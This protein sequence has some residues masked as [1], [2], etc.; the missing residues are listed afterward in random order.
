MQIH[1]TFHISKLRRF[2]PNT[3][4]SRKTGPPPEPEIVNGQERYEVEAIL[5]SRLRRQKLEYLVKW[6]N[7]PRSENTWEPEENVDG[8]DA[9]IAE[10]YR[11]NPSAPR[12]ISAAAFAAM[13]FRPLIC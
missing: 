9:S 3:I 13:N 1:P 2:V 12:R 8:A 11:L 5:D 4:P 10:F 7:F 6:K